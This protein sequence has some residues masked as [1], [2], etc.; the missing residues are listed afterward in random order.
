[1]IMIMKA[2]VMKIVIAIEMALTTTMAVEIVLMMVTIVSE[3][4]RQVGCQHQYHYQCFTD[5]D[6]SISQ[7]SH[8]L[9]VFH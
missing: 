8:T 2:K 1:M 6:Y 9:R 4:L 5:L 3:V 7:I